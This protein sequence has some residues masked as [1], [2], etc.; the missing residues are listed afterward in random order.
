[1]VRRSSSA[2][3]SV[4]SFFGHSEGRA[5]CG[6][7][8]PDSSTLTSGY[9]SVLIARHSTLPTQH[10]DE[11]P[12]VHL[13]IRGLD[14]RSPTDDLAIDARPEFGRAVADRL[15][16]LRGKLFADRCRPNCFY[17]FALNLRNEWLWRVRRRDHAHP[18]VGIH[19]DSS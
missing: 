7:T 3:V 13:D 18:G 1:M 10:A 8:M 9:G 16:Q 14:D 4:R 11:Q 5:P 2:A 17:H 6:G 15:H 19:V 12:S